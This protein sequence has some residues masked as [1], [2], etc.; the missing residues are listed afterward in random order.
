MTTLFCDLVGSVALGERH[1]PEVLRAGLDRYFPVARV[2]VERHG[3]SVEKYP[4][5]SVGRCLRAPD[6]GS[7]H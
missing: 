7:N 1:D 6:E 4:C 2:T 3:G 5:V